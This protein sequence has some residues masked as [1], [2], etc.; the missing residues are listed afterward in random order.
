MQWRERRLRA[1]A[2]RKLV[3]EGLRWPTSDVQK[4]TSIDQ[5]LERSFAQRR[6][7]RALCLQ[8][9]ELGKSQEEYDHKEERRTSRRHSGGVEEKLSARRARSRAPTADDLASLAAID[10]ETSCVSQNGAR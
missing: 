4:M 1:R 3:L 6:Q 9:A 2:W 7:R 5:P 8:I 10:C